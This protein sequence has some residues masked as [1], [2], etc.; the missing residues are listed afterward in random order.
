MNLPTFFTLS[1]L[2]SAPYI[3]FLLMHARFLEALMWLLLAA[4]T[5][6]LDGALAR[7]FSQ[8]TQFGRL[9]DAIA[10]RCLMVAVFWGLCCNTAQAI[11]PWWFVLCM[12]VK[13]SILIVGGCFMKYIGLLPGIKVS[14]YRKLTMAGQVL[15]ALYCIA[16]CVISEAVFVPMWPMYAI[17]AIALVAFIDYGVQILGLLAAKK[18]TVV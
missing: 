18:H 7:A 5:D 11:L 16:Q 6:V 13:E 4:M 8:E 12:L 17:I 3:G 2:V 1:R 10:D 15:L 9:L 14:I